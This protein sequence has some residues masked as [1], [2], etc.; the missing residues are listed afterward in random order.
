[1]QGDVLLGEDNPAL[2]ATLPLRPRF[3]SRLRRHLSPGRSD[4]SVKTHEIRDQNRPTRRFRLCFKYRGRRQPQ[5]VGAYFPSRK[6]IRCHSL[7]LSLSRTLAF[8]LGPPS[9]GR[10]PISW[11]SMICL[12]SR[13]TMTMTNRLLIANFLLP[14]L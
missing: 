2:L 13:M 5:G 8:L 6:C 4:K 1:M 14:Y 12:W 9:A 10:S 7:A 3:R 11:K